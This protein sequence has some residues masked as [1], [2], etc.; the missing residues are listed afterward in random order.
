M[1]SKTIPPGNVVPFPAP[2]R[3]HRAPA[4]APDPQDNRDHGPSP[5]ESLRVMRAFVR[6]KDRQLRDEMIEMLEG[7][8]RT[9]G[10]ASSPRKE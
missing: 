1:G 5:E 3:S 8:S 9:R 10:Q 4:R 6:I 2:K 7:A